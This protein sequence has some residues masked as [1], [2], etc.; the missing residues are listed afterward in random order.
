MRW[1]AIASWAGTLAVAI[2]ALAIGAAIGGTAAGARVAAEA[3]P[4]DLASP[5]ATEVEAPPPRP[6]HRVVGRVVGVRDQLIRVR[7]PGDLPVPVHVRPQTLIRRA[8]E[9][10]G[11]DA[12][13]RGD[14]VV[15]VGRVDEWGVL[16]ARGILVRP[17]PPPRAPAEGH[18]GLEPTLSAPPR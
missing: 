9:R 17:P 5:P 7:P 12:I 6:V 14:R 16:Q 8:G 15:A 11:L 3:A 4:L 18:A 13:R 2:V 1:D 10:V